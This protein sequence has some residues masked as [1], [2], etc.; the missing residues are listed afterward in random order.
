MNNAVS[1][2]AAIIAEKDVKKAVIG[3]P[4]NMNGTAGTSADKIQCSAISWLRLV[5]PCG[6]IFG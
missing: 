2:I 4:L 6:R 5:R 1:Q 3:L